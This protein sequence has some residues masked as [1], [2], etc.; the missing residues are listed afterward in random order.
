[1]DKD[2]RK[3]IQREMNKTSRQMLAFMRGAGGTSKPKYE[4]MCRA[5]VRPWDEEAQEWNDGGADFHTIA[6]KTYV[7]LDA[8]KRYAATL[9]DIDNAWLCRHLLGKSTTVNHPEPNRC[10]TLYTEVRTVGVED[11]RYGHGLHYEGGL[12]LHVRA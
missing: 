2:T 6:R 3:E 8:A 12:I 7:R 11:P 5:E 4:V 10:I 9:D 1:M